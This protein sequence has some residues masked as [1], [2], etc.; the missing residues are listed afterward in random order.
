MKSLFI[1]F[2]LLFTLPSQL[3][4]SS[5]PPP[6]VPLRMLTEQSQVIVVGRII[7]SEET[8][9]PYYTGLKAELEVHQVLQGVV[10]KNIISI[11]M[12]FWVEQQ[13]KDKV[14]DVGR[15]LAFLNV[16]DEVPDIY[17]PSSYQNG[18]KILD[19]AG[20]S[21]YRQRIKEL[22]G[23]NAI[24]DEK[25]RDHL[26]VNWLINCASNG[27][28]YWE[29]AYDLSPYGGFLQ[30]YDYES[31]E[32]ATRFVLS[33]M[34]KQRIRAI[35]LKQ[36]KLSYLELG[37]ITT[38]VN[39]PDPELLRHMIQTLKATD[40]EN[41]YTQQQLMR[42]IATMMERDD[43]QEPL[44]QIISLDYNDEF[45]QKANKIALTFINKL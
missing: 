25:R 14:T 8:V 10:K 32:L 45:E 42:Q 34:Q 39:G 21:A 27:Y 37:L 12:N 19:E 6:P 4:A 11:Y 38:I 40:H 22:Q 15:I 1:A 3:L 43:L 7:S 24:K 23:I 31:E 36:S 33:D 9:L 18:Y 35:V 5:C 41:L 16:H 29:G 26:T 44:D 2:A 17:F 20:I 13:M 28:T 30:Y